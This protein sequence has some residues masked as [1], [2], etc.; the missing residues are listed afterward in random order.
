MWLISW[1]SRL[2]SLC[3]ILII[4]TSTL[5]LIQLD[6]P[7]SKPPSTTEL[8]MVRLLLLEGDGK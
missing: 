4:A 2:L 8:V 5:S 6:S 3:L 1:R 7:V